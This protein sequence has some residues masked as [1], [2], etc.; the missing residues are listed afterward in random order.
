MRINTIGAPVITPS[1][2]SLEVGAT[3]A[4]RPVE[5]RTPEPGETQARPLP[6]I[7]A[8]AAQP[9]PAEAERRQQ[10]RRGEDRRQRQVAVLID[11]RVGQRRAQRRRA[12][13]EVLRAS[14]DVEA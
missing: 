8:P 6:A 4:V 9:L 14:I 2:R 5:V 13:D 11:T 7:P 12:Q 10:A 1:D 3:R